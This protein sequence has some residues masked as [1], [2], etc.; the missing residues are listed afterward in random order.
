METL[1]KMQG[2]PNC[3]LLNETPIK[4]SYLKFLK[5]FQKFLYCPNV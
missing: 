1:K 5:K 3:W 2:E 4:K